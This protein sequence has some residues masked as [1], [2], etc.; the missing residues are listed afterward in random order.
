MG[1]RTTIVAFL[2][3]LPLLAAD[4]VSGEAV[5]QKRC[6][7]CHERASPRVPPRTALETMSATR[8]SRAL[9]SGAM[10]T[11]AYPLTRDERDAVAA[12]LGKAG[13]EPGP[14]PEA[15]CKDRTAAVDDA[16][17]FKWAGWSPTVSNARF[18]PADVAG[19]SID[20]VKR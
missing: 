17:K 10:M 4:P 13:P 12:Y 18:Q 19:L 20:Q 3:A 11:I 1:F 5:Y 16:S 8:I 7:V 2:A 6:A 14:S 9:N 15:Y